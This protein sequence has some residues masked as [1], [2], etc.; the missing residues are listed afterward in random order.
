NEVWS[1]TT[2]LTT[3]TLETYIY[4]LRKK[5]RVSFAG[6]ELI[7]TKKGGYQLLPEKPF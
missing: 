2:S 6:D 7:V 1:H 3:H 4:R 5:I